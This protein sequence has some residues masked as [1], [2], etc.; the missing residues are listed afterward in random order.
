M[1]IENTYIILSEQLLLHVKLK[2][3]TQE[4]EYS[5]KKITLDNLIVCLTNDQHKKTFWINMYNAY[6]QILSTRAQKSSPNIFKQKLIPIAETLFSLDDIEHGILRKYRWKYGLGYLP[7]FFT[8]PIIKQLAVAVIDYRIHFA[9]NCGAKSCPPITFYNI[10]NIDKQLDLATQ[11]FLESET[12]I[13]EKHKLVRVTKLMQWFKAD[14]GGSKGIKDVL[15]N[16]F[17]I[18]VEEYTLRY[19]KYSW[20]KT[21]HNFKQD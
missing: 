18:N 1:N 21:M 3:P 15:T 19:N 2:K 12:M 7:Q 11:T 14:F 13:D 5:I 9:L 20:E 6:F 10:N 8:N 16:Y 4:L 17:K